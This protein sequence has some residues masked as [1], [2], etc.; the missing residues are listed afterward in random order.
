MPV[1]WPNMIPETDHL[2]QPRRRLK[3]PAGCDEIAYGGT[4]TLWTCSM[5]ELSWFLTKLRQFYFRLVPV[6]CLLSRK[7]PR[8]PPARRSAS[9]TPQIGRFVYLER[10]LLHPR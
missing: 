9:S 7:R 1:I 5:A 6:R 8:N 10:V 4:V 2:G 3:V